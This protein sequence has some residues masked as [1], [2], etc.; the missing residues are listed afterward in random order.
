MLA[1]T[2]TVGLAKNGSMHAVVRIRHRQ[3]VRLVDAH[4]AA[5]RRAVEAEA[6][7]ERVLVP[8]FDREGTV[9]P[10][11]EHVDELQVDH[12]G[13][14]LLGKFEEVVGCHRCAPRSSYPRFLDKWPRGGGIGKDNTYKL[15]RNLCVYCTNWWSF[16]ANRRDIHP[17]CG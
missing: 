13:V 1:M 10:G 16:D 5:D 17:V 9:L 11:A 4:P 7:L 14:V 15:I 6:V 12:L 3:H 8:V 2:L